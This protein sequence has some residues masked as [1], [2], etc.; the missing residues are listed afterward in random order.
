[1]V[2]VPHVSHTATHPGSEIPSGFSQ[3]HDPSSSHIFATVVAYTFYHGCHSGIA[4]CEA[5]THSSVDI[6]L[7]IGSAIQQGISG[8]G[9]LFRIEIATHGRQYCNASATQ[10]FA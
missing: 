6:H 8:D 7:T 2:L 1:M 9:I 10:P 5:F 3:Y 4:D